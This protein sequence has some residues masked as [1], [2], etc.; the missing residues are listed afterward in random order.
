MCTFGR[1]G[2]IA[3]GEQYGFISKHLR[4]IPF[5]TVENSLKNGLL[6]LKNEKSENFKM[7]RNRNFNIF[8]PRKKPFPH[9][10]CESVSVT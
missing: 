10:V 2:V 8:S 5:T 9:H 6:N 1:N 7:L 4:P 3:G